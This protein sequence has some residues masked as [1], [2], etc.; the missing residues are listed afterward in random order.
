ML[1]ARL[2]RKYVVY[3]CRTQDQA[4]THVGNIAGI[5]ESQA[6]ADVYPTVGQRLVNEFGHAKGWKR[7]QL[8]SAAGFSVEAYGLDS[9]QRG[10]KIDQYRPDLI[11][12]EIG[13][14]MSCT[15]SWAKTSPPVD[16]PRNTGSS[17]CSRATYPHRT[18]AP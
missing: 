13:T 10:A 18:A 15:P 2:K 14:P 6:V 16:A 5:L 4:D 9:A 11:C 7:S 3:V 1:C 8:R 12:H 17:G